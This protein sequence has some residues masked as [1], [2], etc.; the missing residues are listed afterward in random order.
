MLRTCRKGRRRGLDDTESCWLCPCSTGATR[1]PTLNNAQAHRA[2]CDESS[3]HSSRG[4]CVASWRAWHAVRH[5]RPTAVLS[6]T[7]LDGCAHATPVLTTHMRGQAR[8]AARLRSLDT[9]LHR[10]RIEIFPSRLSGSCIDHLSG[11][12]RSSRRCGNIKFMLCR[13]QRR[14]VERRDE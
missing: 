13:G 1:P 11:R 14:S 9:H 2:T 6:C 3:A 8:R 4:S 12:S 7:L 10:P 5:E